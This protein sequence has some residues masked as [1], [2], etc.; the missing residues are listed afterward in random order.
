M[1]YGINKNIK[2]HTTVFNIAI[3][4]I[5]YILILILKLNV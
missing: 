5:N 2:Q 3:T 4:G 1:Y